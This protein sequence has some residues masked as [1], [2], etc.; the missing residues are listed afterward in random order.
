[1]L[2]QKW[3]EQDLKEKVQ[4]QDAEWDGAKKI[5]AMKILPGRARGQDDAVNQAEVREK[6]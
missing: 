4:E 3:M 5:P 6:I 1:M 2:C